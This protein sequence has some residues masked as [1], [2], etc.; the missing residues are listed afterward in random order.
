M[1]KN[2]S[3]CGTI[4]QRCSFAFREPAAA[5]RVSRHAPCRIKTGT[6]P[7][8]HRDRNQF[9]N[10]A[11]PLPAVE[12]TQIVSAHDPDKTDPRTVRC[13]ISDRIVR[14]TYADLSFDSSDVDA[15]VTGELA[16]RGD[17]FIKGRK[18]Y[19]VLKRIAWRHQP[20]HPIESDSFHRQQASS[21]MR[22]VWWIEGSAEQ[23]D[24][25][26]AIM[27]RNAAIRA[28]RSGLDRFYRVAGGAAWHRDGTGRHGHG[29]V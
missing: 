22:L 11:P 29:R 21:K 13:Q 9:D 10:A 4:R 19:R 7:V 15:G 3:R 18:P 26:P 14:V 17:P 6:E 20:P 5:E 12:A 8:Y 25:L 23:S 1:Q 24:S 27:N 16:R 28:V 2:P